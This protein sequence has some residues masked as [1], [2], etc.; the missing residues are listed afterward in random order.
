MSI[1]LMSV[2]YFFLGHNVV[3]VKEGENR[4][5]KIT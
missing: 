5:T 4:K 1:I 2:G 3:P